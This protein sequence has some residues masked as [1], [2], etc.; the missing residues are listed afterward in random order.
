MPLAY[1]KGMPWGY[2][3]HPLPFMKS[4]EKGV[5]GRK[6]EKTEKTDHKRQ[7]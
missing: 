5:I 4:K 1:A 2:A 7:I 3:P 6:N